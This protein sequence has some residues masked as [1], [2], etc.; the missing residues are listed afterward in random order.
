MHYHDLMTT[1]RI[2]DH[3]SEINPHP[4]KQGPIRR[5]VMVE[6]RHEWYKPLRTMQSKFP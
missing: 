4:D 1:R 5:Q 6:N 3:S 2:R